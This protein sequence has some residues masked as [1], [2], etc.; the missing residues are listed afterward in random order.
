[1]KKIALFALAAAGIL[2]SCSQSSDLVNDLPTPSKEQTVEKTPISFD[3]YNAKSAVVRSSRAGYAGDMTTAML[4]RE[5]FGVIAYYT[6]SDDYSTWTK[7]APNFMYNTKV[8]VD[9]ATGTEVSENPSWTYS[10]TV[11]WPNGNATADN[12]GAAGTGGGKLSFFA[13]AP[14]VAVTPSTGIVTA[15]G[16][17]ATTSITALSSNAAP[18]APTVSYSLAGGV[19]LLWGTAGTN[20]ATVSGNTAQAGTTLTDGKAPVNVDLTKMKTDGK[21]NF[22]FKHALAQINSLK[23][24]ADIDNNGAATGGSLSNTKIYVEKVILANGETG[25]PSESTIIGNGTFDLTTG[26]WTAGSDKETFSYNIS[27]QTVWAEGD[28]ALSTDIQIPETTPN[29]TAGNAWENIFATPGVT[30]TATDV[31]NGISTKLIPGSGQKLKITIKYWVTTK[32]SNLS[33]GYTWIPQE[34]TKTISLGNIEMNK[35]YGIVMHLGL[36]SVKFTAT[37]SDWV[38]AGSEVRADLPVNVVAE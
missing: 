35:S 16:D 17:A 26:L 1:M 11:Y 29:V 27:A 37:V 31:L 24:V 33:K 13:Y 38:A 14:Y 21:I 10:P 12:V 3:T 23:V 9:G 2:S 19:D 15:T 36:T 25:V 28:I 7:E 5:G 6:G 30:T 34:I 18:T 20:G 4:Q 32:D 22:L 8:Y